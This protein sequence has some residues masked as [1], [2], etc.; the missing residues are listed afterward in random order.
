MVQP[1]ESVA[2]EDGTPPSVAHALVVKFTVL[3]SGETLPAASR[4]T[5]FS[6]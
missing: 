4:A 1:V 2:M 3:L 5:T 6:E